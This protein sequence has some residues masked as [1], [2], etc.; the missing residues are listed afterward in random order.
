MKLLGRNASSIM[1]LGIQFFNIRPQWFIDLFNS[2]PLDK[3]TAISQTIFQ[4]HFR[5]WQVLYYDENV[6]EVCS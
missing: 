1:L 2:S 4:M 3:M 5:E 6:I